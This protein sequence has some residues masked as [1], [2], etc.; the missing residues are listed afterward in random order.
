[1]REAVAWILVAL[2]LA[3]IFWPK[4]RQPLENVEEL[5]AQNDSLRMVIAGRDMREQLLWE[6][7]DSLAR[8]HDS[9]LNNMPSAK[10][11]YL[12]AEYALRSAPLDSLWKFMGEWPA[13]TGIAR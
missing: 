6:R 7:A 10:V 9:T 4:D 2:L 8:V 5:K 11:R 13:D 1:M 12:A 3:V